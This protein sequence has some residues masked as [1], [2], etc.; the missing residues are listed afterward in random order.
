MDM[1]R[2][3][4]LLLLSC[5]AGFAAPAEWFKPADMMTIGVY[6][7][8][9][10]WPESQWAPDH[11]NLGKPGVGFAHMGEFAWYVMEPEEGKFDFDWLE[12]NV[13]LASQNGLKV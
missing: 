5:I 13:A 4:A 3:A 1:T 2:T 11:V 8:P 12:K 10:A 7:Y 6:Y 9:E